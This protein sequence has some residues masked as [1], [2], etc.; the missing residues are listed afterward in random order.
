MYEI[1]HNTDHLSES[2]RALFHTHLVSLGI[3]HNIWDVYEKFLQTNSTH[4][5]P[6]I[7]RVN[8]DNELLAAFYV[9]RCED[10]GET[11]TKF[12]WLHKIIRNYGFPVYVWMKS[13]IATENFANP[14]FINQEKN[15]HFPTFIREVKKAF[16]LLFIHD[17]TEN[18]IYYDGSIKI[19]YP[20]DGIIHLN[21][22][23]SIEDYLRLHKNLKKKLRHYKKNGGEVDLIRGK[24][25]NKMQEYVRNCVLSTSKHSIFKLP[26]QENYPNMCV[27]ST[28]IE[29]NQ[30]LH[31]ICRMNNEFLG[32][33][34][35]I[36]FENQMRC[37]HGAFNRNLSTTHHAYEN[38]IYRTVE[39]GLENKID[40]IHYGP[41]LNETKKR[42]M[43]T[44]IPTQL[45][46]FSNIPGMVK[47][48]SPVLKR[49]RLQQ[50]ELLKFSS[51][52]SQ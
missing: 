19:Q 23:N 10:Y 34:T 51:I 20:D 49:S 42:M 27:S 28:S 24:L 30:V 31:F 7:V 47:I 16:S 5:K 14:C 26:Y 12:A 2:E 50:K 8:F 35:F 29:N 1:I 37:M 9:I 38:M 25:D 45:Y 48:L 11:L 17:L 33:H 40:T 22:F 39:Y 6:E 13:G 4:S 41:V 46:L 44:F 21:N 3:D 18:S 15:F 43:E 36:E 52:D 32:Y